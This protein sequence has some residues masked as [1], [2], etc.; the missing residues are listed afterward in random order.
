M[1][2]KYGKLLDGRW[3]CQDEEGNSAKGFTKELARNAYYLQNKVRKSVDENIEK[4]I[5]FE[6]YFSFK[7]GNN[8]S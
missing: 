8:D 5:D 3:L 4:T 2:L 1:E 7:G 6:K